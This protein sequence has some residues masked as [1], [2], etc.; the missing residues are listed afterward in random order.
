[1]H[2]QWRHNFVN[3]SSPSFLPLKFGRKPKSPSIKTPLRLFFFWAF[4]HPWT[5]EK[6]YVTTQKFQDIPDNAMDTALSAHF[7]N[8]W[9]LPIVLTVISKNETFSS[10]KKIKWTPILALTILIVARR[11]S[12]RLFLLRVRPMS[13]SSCKTPH[14]KNTD[15]QHT[16][17]H[18][19]TSPD[20]RLCS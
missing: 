2:K 19:S 1:M 3:C 5:E 14:K 17:A 7:I 4:I 12:R 13:A 16:A 20:R 9:N 18:N 10:K 15:I 6:N 8:P 11:H